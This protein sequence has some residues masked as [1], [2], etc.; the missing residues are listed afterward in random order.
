MDIF[1]ISKLQ[2][3]D[4]S[5]YWWMLLLFL[6]GT[7][8]CWLKRSICKTNI[9]NLRRIMSIYCFSSSSDFSSLAVLMFRLMGSTHSLLHRLMTD[10]GWSWWLSTVGRSDRCKALLGLWLFTSRISI[11]SWNTFVTKILRP[12]FVLH[13]TTTYWVNFYLF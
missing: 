11:R 10:S 12:F 9:L 3:Q 1:Q 2:G 8:L 7:K 5:F 6:T 4:W 13:I